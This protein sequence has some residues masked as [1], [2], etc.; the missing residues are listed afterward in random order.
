MLVRW[1]EMLVCEH[2]NIDVDVAQVHMVQILFK[3]QFHYGCIINLSDLHFSTLKPHVTNV[4][5]S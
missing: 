4:Q 3:P 5:M 1:Y 2:W